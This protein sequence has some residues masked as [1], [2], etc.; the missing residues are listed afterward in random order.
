MTDKT[1]TKR[2]VV[3]IVLTLLIC[4]LTLNAGCLESAGFKLN[5]KG[6]PLTKEERMEWWH[7]ARFG[8]FIHW[9]LYAIPAGE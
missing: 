1:N 6:K 3:W 8:L 7:E 4:G 9:G 5:L 2:Y